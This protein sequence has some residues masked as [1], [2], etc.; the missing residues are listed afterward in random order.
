MYKQAYYRGGAVMNKT[1]LQWEKLF[2][3]D[4]VNNL[5]LIEPSVRHG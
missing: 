2:S 4:R 1:K 3:E 5:G